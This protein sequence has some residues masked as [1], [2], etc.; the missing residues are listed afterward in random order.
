MKKRLKL[1]LS[2]VV[3]ATLVGCQ[4]D[5]NAEYLD[6]AQLIEM[7]DIG[8]TR[9]DNYDEIMNAYNLNQDR[10]RELL[11]QM[12]E[13]FLASDP[14]DLCN[15]AYATYYGNLGRSLLEEY[16]KFKRIKYSGEGSSD[17]SHNVPYYWDYFNNNKA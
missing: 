8:E 16:T 10:E 7:Y 1:F 11:T 17:I 5:P 4:Q 14:N 15:E 9:F 12:I 3:M 2:L 13:L 6:D